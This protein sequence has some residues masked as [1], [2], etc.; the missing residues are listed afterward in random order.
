MVGIAKLERITKN[1]A[2]FAPLIAA[3]QALVTPPAAPSARR[4]T[5][6]MAI[7]AAR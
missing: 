6:A 3:A 1:D 5:V 4:A 7:G 2:D